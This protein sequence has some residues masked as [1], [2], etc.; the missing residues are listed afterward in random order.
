MIDKEGVVSK[1][2]DLL[3]ELTLRYEHI[4]NNKNINSLEYEL[5]EADASYFAK[6]VAVLHKLTMISSLKEDEFSRKEHDSDPIAVDE[7]EVTSFR[8]EEIGSTDISSSL[9]E[10]YE[11]KLNTNEVEVNKTP[12]TSNL[13]EI[14]KDAERKEVIS[15]V[16]ESSY[17]SQEK[18]I[19]DFESTLIYNED[20]RVVGEEDEVILKNEEGSVFPE[21]TESVETTTSSHEVIIEEKEFAFK[22]EPESIDTFSSDVRNPLQS[23][24]SDTYSSSKPQSINERISALKQSSAGANPKSYSGQG[25]SDIKSIINLNDKLLFIKDL[26]NGYS[27]AYSEA[28]ELLN[29][30]DNFSD[31]DL[32]LQSNYAEKNNWQMKKDTVEKFYVILNKRFQ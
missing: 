7:N 22:V 11:N 28:I 2:Q 16:G 18:E 30:F 21:K 19:G 26:F 5:F 9:K 6:Q 13:E 31:A 10:E 14:S 24:L 8:N 4:A 29:R 27:L 17:N 12:I 15:D 32:F 20:E 1:I 3:N 23:S 25:I